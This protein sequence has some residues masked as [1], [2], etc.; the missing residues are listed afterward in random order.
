MVSRHISLGHPLRT[1][2]ST[3]Q[4]VRNVSF[5]QNDAYVLNGWTLFMLPLKVVLQFFCSF[6]NLF[7]CQCSCLFQHFEVYNSTCFTILWHIEIDVD[8]STK[9]GIMQGNFRACTEPSQTSK[10]ELFAKMVN[11][12]QLRLNIKFGNNG[13]SIWSSHQNREIKN[14]KFFAI[15]QL[16]LCGIMVSIK[17]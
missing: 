14:S 9:W 12:L 10:V 15:R 7:L 5:S 6:L 13:N 16:F 1:Y 17:I 4:G 8:I 3:Y 2:A 11:G